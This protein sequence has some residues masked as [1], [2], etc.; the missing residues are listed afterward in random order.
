MKNIIEGTFGREPDG[1][2]RKEGMKMKTRQEIYDALVHDRVVV[3]TLP[4][5][6]E[7]NW[8]LKFGVR[9]LRLTG[10]SSSYGWPFS[11]S[12]RTPDYLADHLW[13]RQNL[14]GAV[15]FF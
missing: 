5:D 11:K 3:E 10:P 4:S 1:W 7:L 8:H 12:A 9:H 15:E 13:R 14:F 2:I 6:E